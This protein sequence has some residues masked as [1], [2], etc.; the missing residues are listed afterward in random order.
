[1]HALLLFLRCTCNRFNGFRNIRFCQLRKQLA[2]PRKDSLRDTRQ[3][4][5]LD[6]VAP[7]RPAPHDFSE[8]DDRVALLLHGNAVIVDPVD[9]SFQLRQF[10]IMGGKQGFRPDEL[11]VRHVFDDGPGEGQSVKC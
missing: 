4:G 1:M 7:V 6:A 5:H 11:P 9:L 10:V 2:G 8:E 3:A